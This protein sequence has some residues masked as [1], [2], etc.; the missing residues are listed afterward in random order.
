MTPTLDRAAVLAS[1]PALT[2]FWRRGVDSGHHTAA[3]ALAEQTADLFARRG[4]V[5]LVQALAALTACGCRT[6]TLQ[7]REFHCPREE[8]C[9]DCDRTVR[10]EGSDHS[11]GVRSEVD[12]AT[13][14]RRCHRTA[15]T[16]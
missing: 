9:H 8:R 14:C 5:S 4:T 16:W 1:L 10:R 12:G 2:A 3:H 11:A 15:H 7:A 6:C 13:R